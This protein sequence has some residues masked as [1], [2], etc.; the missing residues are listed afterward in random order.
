[1][2]WHRMLTL[3]P[4][5]IALS[6]GNARSQQ[7]ADT[8]AL[9]AASKAFYDAVVVVD[10]GTAMEKVWAHKPYITYIGQ[11]V[12]HRRLGSSEEILGRVQ[13][14]IRAEDGRAG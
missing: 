9:R 14:G 3:L 1:M 5:L 2:N 12:D 11:H 4:V 8:E 10:D 13:Q 6:A 7:A